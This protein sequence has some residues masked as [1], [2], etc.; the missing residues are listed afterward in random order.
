MN[1]LDALQR[2][3]S[4]DIIVGTIIELDG[5]KYTVIRLSKAVAITKEKEPGWSG[6]QNNLSQFLVRQV[7][8]EESVF[9][10]ST[11]EWAVLRKKENGTVFSLNLLWKVQT[12]DEFVKEKENVQRTE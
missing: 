12:I 7:T 3:T 6:A 2:M 8:P 11:E 10:F 9:Y 4:N 5:N 1:A